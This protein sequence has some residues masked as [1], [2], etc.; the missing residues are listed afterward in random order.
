MST[1]LGF[2]TNET[3]AQEVWSGSLPPLPEGEYQMMASTCEKCKTKDGTGEYWKFE[4]IVT[5]GDYEGRKIY[6]MFNTINKNETAQNI[7]RSQFKRYMEVIGN[8]NPDTEADLLNIAFL[9][10]I[11]CVD[12]EWTDA[13]GV[14][15]K[16]IKNEIKKIDPI[17]SV[18][19][20]PKKSGKKKAAKES[21][22]PEEKKPW[23]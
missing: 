20:S 22:E 2:D 18:A 16:N 12:N 3:K 1:L 9:A 6:Q 7:G 4:F 11:K 23:D 21:E 8:F 5:D 14:Q 13:N 15:R 17:K 19:S 10:Q